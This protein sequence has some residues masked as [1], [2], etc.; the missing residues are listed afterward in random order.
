MLCMFQGQPTYSLGIMS[1]FQATVLYGGHVIDL[2]VVNYC[3]LKLGIQ[4]KRI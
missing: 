2:G 1:F 4:L 3:C